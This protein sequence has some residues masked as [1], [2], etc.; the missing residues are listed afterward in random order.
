MPVI[1]PKVG[2]HVEVQVF[3]SNPHYGGLQ[4]WPAG[5]SWEPAETFHQSVPKPVGRCMADEARRVHDDGRAT[6]LVR[7]A[8]FLPSGPYLGPLFADPGQLSKLNQ[9]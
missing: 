2:S 3:F 7:F 8:G 4:N 5:S 9:S 1:E 6:W